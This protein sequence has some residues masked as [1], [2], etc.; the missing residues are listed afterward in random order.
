MSNCY[1]QRNLKTD[2]IQKSLC[3]NCI[4]NL[5]MKYL[6]TEPFWRDDLMKVSKDIKNEKIFEYEQKCIYLN[7]SDHDIERIIVTECNQYKYEK[8]AEIIQ[9]TKLFEFKSS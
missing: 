5:K 1:P 3:E 2:E 8:I 6:K 7:F 9:E 4:N